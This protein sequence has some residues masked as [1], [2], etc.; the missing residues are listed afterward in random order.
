MGKK[1]NEKIKEVEDSKE[2]TS[3]EVLNE[4]I[5]KYSW[6]WEDNSPLDEYKQKTK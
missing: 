1:E 6:L 4:Y 5:K 3:E 2:K